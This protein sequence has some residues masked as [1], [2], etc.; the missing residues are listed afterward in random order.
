MFPTVA[1]SRGDHEDAMADNGSRRDLASAVGMSV[2][3]AGTSMDGM[4]RRAAVL[5]FHIIVFIFYLFLF[6][7]LRFVGDLMVVGFLT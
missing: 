3:G 7:L 4:Q 6:L 2:G 1:S 5:F